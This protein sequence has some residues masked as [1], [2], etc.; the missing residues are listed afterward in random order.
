MADLL[1]EVEL[2]Q[3]QEQTLKE[4]P[5]FLSQHTT[6]FSPSN[7]W[8]QWASTGRAISAKKLTSLTDFQASAVQII[9][10]FINP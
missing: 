4:A 6:F 7:C 10:A 1:R 9:L 5:F 8:V 2:R 3:E